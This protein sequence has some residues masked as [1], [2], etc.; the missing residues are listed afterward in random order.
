MRQGGIDIASRG[1]ILTANIITMCREEVAGMGK[2]DV[3]AS[4]DRAVTG[5]LTLIN[6][7]RVKLYTCPSVQS[8]IMLTQAYPGNAAFVS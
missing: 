8:L 6:Q 2:G 5:I 3:A 1:N 4:I 7:P